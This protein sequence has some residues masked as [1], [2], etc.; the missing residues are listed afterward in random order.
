VQGK[1]Y[2]SENVDWGRYR[3]FKTKELAQHEIDRFPV[4]KNLTVYYYPKKPAQSIVE[5]VN[6]STAHRLPLLI[7]TIFVGVSLM[8]FITIIVPTDV[9]PLP[10]VYAVAAA[11]FGFFFAQV[12]PRLKPRV[13]PAG[14]VQMQGE[15]TDVFMKEVPQA[16]S[17]DTEP[18]YQLNASFKY[19]FNGQTYTGCAFL[20]TEKKRYTFC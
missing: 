5:L 4:G 14:F 11:S 16:Y 3:S 17:T 1:E 8:A 18:N 13:T 10:F 7:G 15:I 12:L 20:C 19:V 9:K 2:T 6:V